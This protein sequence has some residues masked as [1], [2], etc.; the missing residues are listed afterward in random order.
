MTIR[1]LSRIAAAILAVCM[2]LSTAVFADDTG[3]GIAYPGM[4]KSLIERG[5]IDADY[6][7]FEPLTR[8]ELAEILCRFTGN[9][10]VLAL[11]N[12]DPDADGTAAANELL[13]ALRTDDPAAADAPLTFDDAL[14]ILSAAVKGIRI[15]DMLADIFWYDDMD[16]T[17]N[18]LV[19]ILYNAGIVRDNYT[20]SRWKKQSHVDIYR[21]YSR[22]T[23]GYY[24]ICIDSRIPN[25]IRLKK[26]LLVEPDTLYVLSADVMT[27]NVVNHESPDSGVGAQ[28]STENYV[29]STCLTGTNGW[30]TLRKLVRSDKNG[31][32]P[33]SLDLGYWGATTTGKVWYSNVKCTPIDEYEAEDDTWNFL[34]VIVKNAFIDQQNDPITGGRTKI[35]HSR[36]AK[37]IEGAKFNAGE[38]T[39]DLAEISRGQIKAELDIIVPEAKLEVKDRHSVGF[40]VSA[41]SARKYLEASGIDY[42][43]YDHVILSVSLPGLRT[44]YGGLGGTMIDGSVGFSFI[45]HT[46]PEGLKN[47]EKTRHPFMSAM[48]VHEFLHSIETYSKTLGFDYPAL[49]DAEEYGYTND[50]EWKQW[51]IDYINMQVKSGGKKIGIDPTVWKLPPANFK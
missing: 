23:E 2:L 40:H 51:Y 34:Y 21:D 22:K 18:D 46:N 27:E 13:L 25:D 6:P 36:D 4:E 49:H 14:P 33:F 7:R 8:R 28:I 19:P 3:T 42:S 26:T 38:L 15:G 31:E 16:F 44:E 43:G 24:S 29:H 45:I 12:G 11:L 9:D 32:L 47:I 37:E 30:T 20:L 50:N 41:S 1:A 17:G 5:I 35:S 48:F 10:D 39:K